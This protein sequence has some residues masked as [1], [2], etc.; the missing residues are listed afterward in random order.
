MPGARVCTLAGV[1]SPAAD[2]GGSR[3]FNIRF[4][5][6]R[7]PGLLGRKVL[8]FYQ[9]FQDSH[10]HIFGSALMN[11]LNAELLMPNT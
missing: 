2:C 11:Y 5:S 4:P 1:T 3:C 6:Q 9:L 8:R 10:K 7:E